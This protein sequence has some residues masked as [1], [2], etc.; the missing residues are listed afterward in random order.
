MAEEEELFSTPPLATQPA[1]QEEIDAVP[2]ISQTPT[3]V[4]PLEWDMDEPLTVHEPMS[5][6]ERF[7]LQQQVEASLRNMYRLEI[8]DPQQFKNWAKSLTPLVATYAVDGV[9]V[10]RDVEDAIRMIY[11]GMEEGTRSAGLDVDVRDKMLEYRNTI[12]K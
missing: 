2:V 3:D 9:I 10:R 4:L 5:Y 7:K 11:R 6:H 8:S 12:A 1:T